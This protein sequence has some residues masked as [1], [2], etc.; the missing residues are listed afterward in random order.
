MAR[1]EESNQRIR[2]EQKRKILSVAT[3]VFARKGLVGTKMTDIATE[4]GIGY[5]LLY[6]YFSSK[7]LIF[8]AAVE[9]ATLYGFQILIKRIQEQPGTPWERLYQ[10]TTIILE[11]ILREPEGFLLSQQAITS[12]AVPQEIKE[13][14]WLHASQGI[15]EFQ[16]LIIEGQ[17]AG[18]VATGDSAELANLYFACI[19]GIAMNFT[20]FRSPLSNYPKPESV[21]RLLKA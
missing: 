8:K 21:L 9:R 6:H 19:G 20:N 16:Q 18:Q 11:G 4:A 2:D 17:T 10:L 13:M 12:D 15:E 14:V 7:E 1:T 3:R 5:G